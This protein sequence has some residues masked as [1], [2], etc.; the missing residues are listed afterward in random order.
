MASDWHPKDIYKNRET[1]NK[2]L[3][4]LGEGKYVKPKVIG[5]NT[6][7]VSIFV[8][9]LKLFGI[10]QVSFPC[11]FSSIN[12]ICGNLFLALLSKCG[13]KMNRWTIRLQQS[14]DKQFLYPLVSKT[15]TR[16]VT[17]CH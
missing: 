17:S 7:L 3:S 10:Y 5:L 9:I 16:V 11:G 12:E 14:P 4:Q 1:A 15:N 2:G 8:F 6:A 13:N